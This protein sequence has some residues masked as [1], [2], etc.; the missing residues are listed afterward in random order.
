VAPTLVI[1]N[2]VLVGATVVVG[3]FE[4]DESKAVANFTAHGVSFDE[5]LGAFN[6]PNSVEVADAIHPERINVIGFSGRA[7]LLFVVALERGDRT[8]IISARKATRAEERLY[9]TG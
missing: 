6:D 3:E 5:A 9:E 4:W 1:A 2:I 8:R 7:R